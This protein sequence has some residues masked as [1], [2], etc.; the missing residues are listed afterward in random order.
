M[1][2]EC[3][4]TNWTGLVDQLEKF[5]IYLR[6]TFTIAG[7]VEVGE[8]DKCT[9]TLTASQMA[10]SSVTIECAA[11]LWERLTL[12]KTTRYRKFDMQTYHCEMFT[13][14]RTF[15]IVTGQLQVMPLKR[16]LP[17]TGTGGTPAKQ[18]PTGTTTNTTGTPTNPIPSTS[19]T[20]TDTV[21][22]PGE[23]NRSNQKFYRIAKSMN[24]AVRANPGLLDPTV[25]Q[26]IQGERF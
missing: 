19:G 16:T 5:D 23:R 9:R 1:T 10:G 6:Y 18:T 13:A 14:K 21:S 4:P 11:R 8:S 2:V 17:M 7:V 25:W 12:N 15:R 22:P 20:Q 3:I 26:P 24:Q